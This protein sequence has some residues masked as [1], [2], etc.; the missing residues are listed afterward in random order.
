MRYLIVLSPLLGELYIFVCDLPHKIYFFTFLIIPVSSTGWS[1]LQ[2]GS[3]WQIQKKIHLPSTFLT[4]PPLNPSSTIPPPPSI[5]FPPPNIPLHPQLSIKVLFFLSSHPFTTIP[6]YKQPNSKPHQTLSS[7][8]PKIP[9]PC[10]HHPGGN[11]PTPLSL[12]TLLS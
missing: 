2:S 1:K 6:A 12:A 4:F 3:C 7:F 10:I 9:L 11:Q 8:P 5:I